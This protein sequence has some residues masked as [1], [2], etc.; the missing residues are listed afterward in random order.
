MPLLA[1]HLGDGRRRGVDVH[2]RE[3]R[4]AV[5]ADAVGE[6]LQAPVFDLGDLAAALLDDPL[7]CSVR[8]RPAGSTRPA[9]PE[10]RARRAAYFPFL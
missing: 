3:V 2:Q 4:L 6:G 8:L 9:G 5:L 7:N 1:L 10:I